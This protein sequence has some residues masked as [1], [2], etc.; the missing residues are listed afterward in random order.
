[1]TNIFI[2][3]YR[4]DFN[5]LKYCLKS[6]QKFATGFGKTKILVPTEDLNELLNVIGSV[7]IDNWEAESG[8]EWPGKGF[9]WHEAQICRADEWLPDADIIC[10]F[11]PDCVF[12][13]PVTPFTFISNDGRPFLRYESFRT[14]GKRH[15]GVL[16]WKH[17]AELCV[18]FTVENEYMRGFCHCY[19]RNTYRKIREVVEK[20]TGMKFD[21]YVKT[22]KNDFPQTFAEHVT[23]GAVAHKYLE[24]E[25]ILK[26]C[27]LQ[28]NPDENPYPV[29]QGWSHSPPDRP[30]DLWYKGKVSRMVPLDKFKELGLC[31]P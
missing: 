21:D 12:T 28:S 4:K 8:E 27:G 20:K 13:E 26:D 17:A 16:S 15:P 14:I 25:Y 31:P 7:E 3:T 18:P 2:V 19:T 29:F 24:H 6:I 5:W 1:M 10:H 30:V 22:C 9:L 23:L 11:D